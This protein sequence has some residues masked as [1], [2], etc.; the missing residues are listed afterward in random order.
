MTTTKQPLDFADWYDQNA[1][2]LAIAWAESG[3][4]REGCF[5][6]ERE[7]EKAYDHYVAS[8]D[9][10]ETPQERK[11][12]KARERKQRQREREERL[13]MKPW[14][15]KFSSGERNRI[16]AGAAAAG[17]EDH[18]EYLFSLVMADTKELNL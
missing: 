13:D 5:D 16:A 7:A 6:P 3:R 8:F 2:D 17:F 4:D 10:Q 14:G 9:L 18:T 1:D 11:R 15:G 12:R